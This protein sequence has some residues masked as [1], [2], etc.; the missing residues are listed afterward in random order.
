MNGEKF[1]SL[2]LFLRLMECDSTKE[3][4]SIKAT[5]QKLVE[6][7]RETL[8]LK[9]FEKQINLTCDY[10]LFSSLEKELNRLGMMNL[11]N[12]ITVCS[13]HDGQNVFKNALRKMSMNIENRD[14]EGK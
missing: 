10:A 7:L 3:D 14:G 6:Y 1:E 11:Q 4:K 9:E 2:S 12:R 8:Y 5:A 13:T